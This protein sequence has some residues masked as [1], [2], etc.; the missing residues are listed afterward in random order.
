M[1]KLLLIGLPDSG[2]VEQIAAKLRLRTV[3]IP[4]E[5]YSR[6]LGSLVGYANDSVSATAA[7]DAVLPETGLL[8]MCGLKNNRIDRLLQALRMAGLVIPHKAVL[9]Q[10]NRSWNAF[11][12]AHELERERRAMMEK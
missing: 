12:L 4:P 11:Q 1:E 7:A 2:T 8:V 6:S 3:I 9:T 5:Q 10:T